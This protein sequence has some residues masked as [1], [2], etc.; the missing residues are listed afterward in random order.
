MQFAGSRAEQS[1][2]G[3]LCLLLPIRSACSTAGVVTELIW[4]FL[5]CFLITVINAEESNCK[6]TWMRRKVSSHLFGFTILQTS[7]M[8]LARMQAAGVSASCDWL[9]QLWADRFLQRWVASVSVPYSCKYNSAALLTHKYKANF[10][11]TS[12][13]SSVNKSRAYYIFQP[14]RKTKIV[15]NQNISTDD[16]QL[17]RLARAIKRKKW[18]KDKF[19]CTTFNSKSS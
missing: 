9:L 2:P 11:K 1:T 19:I 8:A 15:A 3:V 5:S 13:A 14:C 4:P 18:I 6:R 16:Y 10:R 12:T 7:I 17:S